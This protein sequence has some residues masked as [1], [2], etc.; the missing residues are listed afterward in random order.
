VT[1]LYMTDTDIAT[2]NI[3]IIKTPDQRLRVF[4]SSTLQELAHER[5]AACNSI[6][7][8]HLIPVTFES[9]ARPHPPRELYRAY[10]SQSHVFIGIYW[11]K[12]G[13]VAPD[14][15]VSGIED[16][17]NLSSRMPRL[18]YL[19][20]PA[21]DQESSLAQ[22]LSRI[23][24]ENSVS[25]KYFSSPEELEELIEDDLAIFLSERF[26]HSF[27]IGEV[28]QQGASVVPNNLPTV[29]NQFIGRE[30]LVSD[31]ISSIKVDHHR[32][33]TFTGAGGVGKTRLALRVSEELIELFPGGV[34]FFDLASLSD[35]TLLIQSIAA[36]L[37]I[38]E[39]PGMP[40]INSLTNRIAQKPH[41]FILD[42]C[43]H[44]VN[45][46][47]F[48]VED[49]LQGS[50]NLQII[51]TSRESM[52]VRGEIIISI[53]PLSFPD[54]QEELPCRQLMEFDAVKLFVD[55][56]AAS[57]T[58][59]EI[60]NESAPFVAKICAKLDGIPLAIEL[61]AA[62][63]RVLSAEEIA[64]RLNDNFNFLTGTRTS[65]ARQK[66]LTALIDWSHELLSESERILFRRLSVF[67]NSWTLEAAEQV[68][69]GGI[70]ESWEILDLLT[71]LVEK[72]FVT[73]E[74]I[75]SGNRYRFLEMI[76]Q[77]SHS[78]LVESGEADEV[79]SNFAIYYIE[80]AERSY[81]NLWGPKQSYCLKILQQETDNMRSALEWLSISSDRGELLLRMAGSLWR[82]WE[83]RGYVTEG[84]GWLERALASSPGAT[85][86]SRANGL[87]G[88]GILAL[89]QGDL[90]QAREMHEQSL[91]LFRELGNQYKIGVARELGALAEIAYIQ[92][93]YSQATTLH[94]ESLLLREEI[95][96]KEGIAISLGH[97][98]I[99]A[100]DKGNYKLAIELLEKSL[101]LCREMEDN[102]MTAFALRNLGIAVYYQCD[103]QQSNQL[104]HQ[105]LSLYRE[106]DDMPGISNTLQNL[107]NTA[108]DLGDFKQAN[109]LYQDCLQI[110]QSL[111][112]R[113]GIA[114]A[115]ASLAELNFLQ[116]NYT[117]AVELIEQSLSLFLEL[118]STRGIVFSL[119]IKAY[120]SH[121]QGQYQRAEHLARE[122]LALATEIEAPRPIAYAK[123]VFGLNALADGK[124]VEAKEMLFESLNI[125]QEVNDPRSIAL[126]LVNLAR[127]AYHQ[128]DYG[129]AK[130]F[131]DESLLIAQDL[132]ILWTL[133]FIYEIMGLLERE[134]GNYDQALVYLN[135]SIKISIDQMNQQGIANCLGAF[136]GLAAALNESILAVRL[137]SAADK[138]RQLIGANM[139]VHDQH[140]YSHFCTQLRDKLDEKSLNSEWFESSKLPTEQIIQELIPWLNER[141]LSISHN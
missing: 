15:D 87:R 62:R 93:D 73:V 46:V 91:S 39:E 71:N 61:A 104:L 116:G 9:G 63:I 31:I 76:R 129:C 17:Y 13:W 27:Q 88:A 96:D 121:Y 40:L 48:L 25:Y 67:N 11:Q 107:G 140:E 45:D 80:L 137:F 119:G 114:Q 86:Y 125:F 89:K 66:T 32:L 82:F 110:K 78:Q 102:L 1:D 44:L 138:L 56:A 133:S 72:S 95:R 128:G 115:A 117:R 55:R 37:G 112:D 58:G 85:V 70:I 23:Q 53:P 59:Y 79:S 75:E 126:V 41:L 135:D 109:L 51:A 34:W 92:G 22:L 120:I 2:S 106:S 94:K 30:D 7:R 54:S 99:I 3:P 16:E 122:C 108:K 38:S 49:L 113:Y 134:K 57:Q 26:E 6:K 52:G 84:R 69:Q 20:K 8:L 68:C 60:T 118:E 50:P 65:L 43:E 18:V 90:K 98:G 47:A 24:S 36:D 19:K 21:P 14:M 130:E 28:E 139:G 131:L 141:S 136:A 10:L 97:L 74:L 4:I 5:E 33:I 111:G 81:G 124:L 35:S 42:N 29:L 132:E 105:A 127:I 64:W 123:Q 83:I 103:Y 100:R 101:Q 12:Y 77:F